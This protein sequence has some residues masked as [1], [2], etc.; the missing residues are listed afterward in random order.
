M[1][2]GLGNLIFL[3]LVEPDKPG[4]R[5]PDLTKYCSFRVLNLVPV[6]SGY[7]GWFHMANNLKISIKAQVFVSAN[8]YNWI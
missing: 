5:Y 1:Y 8:L 3:S 7:N 2:S 4:I 6:E